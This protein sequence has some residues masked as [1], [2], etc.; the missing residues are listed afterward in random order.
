MNHLSFRREELQGAALPTTI[1]RIETSAGVRTLKVPV[2]RRHVAPGAVRFERAEAAASNGMVTGTG[3][4]FD[5]DSLDLGDFVE[6]I[7][8]G[9]TRKILASKPDVVVGFNH[10]PSQVLGRTSSKTA[11]I[12]AD[13]KG[14]HYSATPPETD[15]AANVRTLIERGDVSGSSFIFIPSEERWSEREDGSLLCTVTEIASLFEMGPV[16]FPAYQATDT[17][18]RLIAE[19]EIKAKRTKAHRD[20]VARCRREAMTAKK[21]A[22]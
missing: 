11:R 21:T 14:V 5:S 13:A 1:Y 3:I 17:Y 15:Y 9:A 10:D 7:D 8:R 20:L 12:W 18:A 2:T 4:V 19:S 22:A 16:T 6:R